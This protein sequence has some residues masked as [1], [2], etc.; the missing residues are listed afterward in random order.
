M[1]NLA[2]GPVMPQLLQLLGQQAQLAETQVTT[3]YRE[4]QLKEAKDNAAQR[5][6]TQQILMQ[7]L[8][9]G[10]QAGIDKSNLPSQDDNPVV[11]AQKQL[12]VIQAQT[13]QMSQLAAAVRAGGDPEYADHLDS[14]VNQKQER[15]NSLSREMRL[16]QA[17]QLK[18][19]GA[20]AA[21]ARDQDTFSA[22][23]NSMKTIDP[24]V[25]R[26]YSFDRDIDGNPVWGPKTARTMDT[27]KEAGMTETER[28]KYEDAKAT[29]GD[30]AQA[31]KA[32]LDKEKADA[33]YAD[34]RAA[35]E[36]L[37]LKRE[38][39]GLDPKTG[40]PPKEKAAPKTEEDKQRD[41]LQAIFARSQRNRRRNPNSRKRS[42]SRCCPGQGKQ[43]GPLRAR[44]RWPDWP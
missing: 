12:K 15:Y 33:L 7:D 26:K 17:N 37:H 22:S 25:S 28:A 38:E 24:D 41:R 10:L 31:A 19:M 18:T 2:M 34:S 1:P 43:I 21:S 4:E 23:L 30:R 36:G 11:A 39:Q 44:R 8:S 6:R 20:Y 29:A 35:L 42:C 27:I 5:Q 3:Q 9:G 40:L 13:Q 14:I 32:K 16:E